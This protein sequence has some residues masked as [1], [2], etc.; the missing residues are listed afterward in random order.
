M[1]NSPADTKTRGRRGKGGAPGV[2]TDIPLQPLRR[3]M[4]K[5]VVLLQLM[6]D[7]GGAGIH[8]VDHGGPQAAASGCF[9][10]EDA[11][12]KEA[13]LEQGKSVKRKEQQ[14]VLTSG[15]T[16]T[17]LPI[18]HPQ[19]LLNREK[20]LGVKLSWGKGEGKMLF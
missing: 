12:C 15:L 9:L 14:R 10:K 19:E 17:P 13:I 5:Q 6:E 4:V 3:T 11:T 20:G 8:T 1:R 16:T 2:G 7:H 18:L